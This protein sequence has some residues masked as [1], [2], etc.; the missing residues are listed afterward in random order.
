MSENFLAAGPVRKAIHFEGD[1][2]VSFGLDGH[3]RSPCASCQR[4]RVFS[5]ATWK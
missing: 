2:S 5:K 4:L 3:P 1:L